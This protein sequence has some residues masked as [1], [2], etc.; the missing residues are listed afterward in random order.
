MSTDWAATINLPGGIAEPDDNERLPTPD[1]LR[2]QKLQMQADIARRKEQ[3]KRAQ[4]GMVRA[5]E[6][7]P[8]SSGINRMKDESRP[9]VKQGGYP[10]SSHSP[11][12]YDGPATMDLDGS[13]NGVGQQSMKVAPSANRKS[14]DTD[15]DDDIPTIVIPSIPSEDSKTPTQQRASPKSKAKKSSKSASNGGGKG[16]SSSNNR[17][18]NNLDPDEGDVASAVS[19]EVTKKRTTQAE[20]GGDNENDNSPSSSPVPDRS[21]DQ[22][23]DIMEDLA[24]FVFQPAPQGTTVKCRITRDKKG[25]DRGMYPTY[26][27]HMERD[28]GKKVFMLAGRKRKKSKTSNYLMSIDPTDLGRDG[29]AFVGKLRSNFLGTQFTIYDNGA[30]PKKG[31]STDLSK[32]RRELVAVCYETNVLGFKGPRKMTVLLPGMTAEGNRTEFHPINDNDGMIKRWE[33]HNMEGLLEL[34]NKSPIWNED[35]QSYVLNFHGRVTQASVKNFQIVHDNEVDYVVMQ[36]GRVSE[37]VFTMDYSYPMCAV[38]AFG[39]AL[40]SFDGKLACE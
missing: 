28:D 15:S 1:T 19:P 2:Q 20:G 25:V 32:I 10:P 38:Q 24:S 27:L 14:E 6:V 18:G 40:T 17:G 26:Y 13:S 35:T 8:K 7:R 22:L 29:E 21:A 4:P 33:K 37:D 36:F 34:H 16:T 5:S 31:T 23:V 30:S 9:L 11:F 12:A 39:V 3:Q